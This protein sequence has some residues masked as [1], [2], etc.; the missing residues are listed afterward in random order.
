MSSHEPTLP[1]DLNP[2]IVEGLARLIGKITGLT[3]PPANCFPSEWH[4]AL[5]EFY[6][7]VRDTAYVNTE[8]SAKEKAAELMIAAR[9]AQVF[10]DVRDLISTLTDPYAKAPARHIEAKRV[11]P[12]LDAFLGE[13]YTGRV[14][15]LKRAISAQADK[16]VPT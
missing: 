12:L 5:R 9:N 15:K 11:L 3:P 2:V 13:G 14:I 6:K 10:G 4:G 1:D 8:A 16:G 7:L